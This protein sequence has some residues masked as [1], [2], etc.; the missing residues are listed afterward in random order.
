MQIRNYTQQRFNKDLKKLLK[1]AEG[2]DYIVGIGRG[3]LSLAQCL[4]YKTK[5]PFLYQ[6]WERRDTYPIEES[7][8]EQIECLKNI[9]LVDEICDSGNT[10]KGVIDE[11]DFSTLRALN[12]YK[13]KTMSLL[14]N[15][16]SCFKPDF[17]ASKYNSKAYY[18]FWWE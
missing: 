2:F 5:T 18:K 10:F 1:Q 17:Y 3:S 13:I 4:S 9:L 7:I 12:Q 6:P 15:E 8:L 11:I 14:Y 16:R